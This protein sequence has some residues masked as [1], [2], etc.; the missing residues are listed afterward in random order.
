MLLNG[1][2]PLKKPGDLRHHT[3]LHVDWKDAEASWRMWLLAAGLNGI[4]PTR[5]RASQWKPWRC[6]HHHQR[7]I[8]C[9]VDAIA[10]FVR[11]YGQ[12]SRG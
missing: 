8:V 2:H 4:D 3:L 7:H 1:E 10:A 11:L 5:V 12:Q 9:D 6:Y